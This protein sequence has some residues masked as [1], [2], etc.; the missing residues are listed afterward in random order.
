MAGLMVGLTRAGE[1]RKVLENAC[2]LGAFVAS[3]HGATPLFPPDIV[4]LFAQQ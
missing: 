3:H 2:R 1:T 4:Q